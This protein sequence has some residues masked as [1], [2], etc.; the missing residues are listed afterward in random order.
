MAEASEKKL[1]RF[2]MSPLVSAFRSPGCQASS[3][4]P[5]FSRL[6]NCSTAG[7]KAIDQVIF[8]GGG[9]MRTELLSSRLLRAVICAASFAAF[10]CAEQQ[11][12]RQ[13]PVE[14]ASADAPAC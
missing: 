8:A 11:A 14:P 3:A 6:H 2:M 10:A 7:A 1:G 12:Q 4:A 13:P 9:L 5:S